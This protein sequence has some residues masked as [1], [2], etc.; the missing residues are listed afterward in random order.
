MDV[1]KIK[2]ND[3][4]SAVPPTPAELEWNLSDLDGDDTGRNQSGNLFRDR[5]AVKRK[6]KCTWLPMDGANMSKLLSAVTDPFFELT[7]PDALD[8]KN[9]TITCYVGDRSAPIMRPN[10]DGVWLWGQISMNFIE[11]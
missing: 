6:I 2:K 3:G 10:N 8:G 11:R 4:T 9:R 7:Y 1:L 5:V